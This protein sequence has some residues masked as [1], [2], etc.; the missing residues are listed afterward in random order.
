MTLNKIMCA[1]A[2]SLASHAA[3]AGPASSFVDFSNGAQGWE[4]TQP[5]NGVGGSGIDDGMGNGAPALRTVIENFGIS[6]GNRS[7]Q[8]YLGDYSRLGSVTIGL[9]VI[10]NSIRYVGQEVSRNLVVELRDYGNTPQGMPYTSVWFNLGAID[11]TMGWQH[12]SVTIADTAAAALPA[13]WGGYGSA[14]DADG[15]GLPPGRTFADVLSSVDELVFSTY[16]PGWFYGFTDFDV[17][18]D[19]IAVD[20]GPAEVPEPSTW[21]LTIGGLGMLGWMTRR[22]SRGIARA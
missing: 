7:N 3:M 20:A 9:D 15:P 4:G 2:L 5:A 1:L 13:G 18:I 21:A 19:N 22:R 8:N 10:A 16:V 11:H 6:F 17:A 12:L 14:D